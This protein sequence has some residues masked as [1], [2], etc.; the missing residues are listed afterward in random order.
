MD[1]LFGIPMTTIMIVLLVMLSICVA[2]VALIAIRRPVIF[3]LGIR[4]IPRRKAQTSLIVIGL[5]LATL[6]ITAALGTGD[7]LNRSVNDIAIKTLGPLDEVVVYSSSKD[8]KGEISAAFTHDIPVS[9]VATVQTALSGN[10]NVD[11]IGGVLYSQ[12]P[13][14]NLGTTPPT[15]ASSIDQVLKQ[16]TQSEPNVTV[17]GLDQKT[18]DDV[19]GLKDIDGHTIQLADLGAEGVILGRDG[20]DKLNASVG[21]YLAFSINNQFHI[22]VVKG[23]APNQVLTGSVQPG[24]PSMLM[25]LSRLQ[26]LTGKQ[27]LVSGVGISNTGGDRGGL[28]YSDGIVQTLE[29]ALKDAGLGVTA[30]KKD[31]VDAAELIAN[32]FV[33][34]FIVFGLFSIGV[35]I[36]LIVL[37]FTMLAAERRAEMGMQRAIGAQR[38]ALIQQFIAEGTGYALVAGLIGVALGILATTGIALGIGSIFGGDFKITPYVKAQSM[39]SAY[40]LGVV[41]TFIAIALSSWRVS[42]LNVVAAVRD[43]PDTYHAVRNRKQLIWAIVMIVV[44][45]LGLFAGRSTDNLFLFGIGFTLLPFGIAGIATYMGMNPRWVLSFAGIF[46]LVFWLLPDSLSEKLFG[47]FDGGIEMFFVSGICIVAAST[48]VILQNLDALLSVAERIGDRFG[49]QLPAIRLAVSYPSAS[50]SRTGMTIAMFSLIV[51]SLVMVAAI[52]TNFA[53]AFLGDDANAGWDIRVDIP[54]A[55]PVGDFDAALQAKG[56]DTAQFQGQGMLLYPNQGANRAQNRDDGKWNL[57]NVAGMDSSFLDNASVF[58]SARANGYETDQAVLDAL[59]TDPHAAVIDA[60]AVQGGSSF[61]PPSGLVVPGLTT[62]GTF[63]AQNLAIDTGMGSTQQ[64]KIIGVI[65]SKISTLLGVFVGPP[66]TTRLFPSM[67]TPAISHFIKL[68]PGV[69]AKAVAD[70]I[71]RALISNGAQ[72][73]DIKQELKDG[74]RQQQSFLYILQG[75]MGLGLIVGIAAVGVIA[76]RAVVERRQEIGMLRALGFQRSMIAQAFVMESAIVVILGV[77]TGAV[78][79]L[80]LAYNLMTGSFFTDGGTTPTFIV[81]WSTV[82]VTLLAAVLASLLMAWLPARQASR[83]MPAEALRY[84]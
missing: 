18:L 34:F 46:V 84:E 45:A 59:K 38:G 77:L 76:F 14:L 75:F 7:T 6:I 63:D 56:I 21:D 36:L 40:S 50:K 28:R 42:R 82:I 78:F 55:N 64:V 17:A 27:G 49:S 60:S 80:I 24:M 30:I 33:T 29:P 51:F 65:D 41:I 47:K 69:N 68:K 20:A 11:A 57:V 72:G 32:I 83:I 70:N 81:P 3:K 1:K 22:A 5:M 52:N 67:T 53:A 71:E 26:E 37:I 54:P 31:N 48:L 16:A 66:A 9:A 13:V 73:V 39:I 58:F 62:T 4:N 61:G 10:D 23:I 12:A 44:G 15:G 35:G 79:G 2:S 43:I 8:G 25:S 19:G 74:Q